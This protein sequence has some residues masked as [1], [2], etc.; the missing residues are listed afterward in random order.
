[1]GGY[2]GPQGMYYCSVGGKKYYGRSLQKN[3]DLCIQ[4]VLI[5]KELIKRLQWS[6]GV[7]NCF[8]RAKKGDEL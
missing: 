2:P 4:L 6:V 1:M 5:L 8:Q 3:I 7:S